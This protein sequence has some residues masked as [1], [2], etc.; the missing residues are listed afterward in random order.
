MAH[1]DNDKDRNEE[2][3][4]VS[5]NK[6][7]LIMLRKWPWVLLSLVIWISLAFFYLKVKQPTY[8]RTGKVLIKDEE[9]GGSIANPLEAFADLGMFSSNKVLLDEIIKMESPD[10]MEMVVRRLN[11]AQR[12]ETPGKWHRNV[13]YGDSLPVTVIAPSWEDD[14][15]ASITINIAKNGDVTLSDL[16][17]NG[18]DEDF[19]QKTPGKLGIP[20]KTP[21]GFVTVAPTPGYQPGE[22]YTLYMDRMPIPNAVKFYQSNTEIIREDEQANVV[23]LTVYDKSG[24]RARDIISGIIDVYNE[25]WET[26]KDA[27]S[28]A[29]NKFIDER[30]RNIEIELGAIDKDISQ[31]Q[32]ENQMPDIQTAAA[33]YLQDNQLAEQHLLELTNLVRVAQYLRDYI[34]NNADKNEILPTFAGIGMTQ[35]A[36][37]RQIMEYNEMLSERNRLASNSSTNHPMIES[38]D[39]QLK[40]MRAAIIKSADNEIGSLNAQIDNVMGKKGQVE[41]QIA[42]API[43]ASEL[44]ESGRQQK[45]LENLYLFL[46]QKREENVLSQAFGVFNTE[47][48]ARPNGDKAPAKPRKMLILGFA[49][50][51]G[52]LTPFSIF[53]IQEVFNT[54]VTSKKDLENISAPLIGE[55][56]EWKKSKKT[57]LDPTTDENIV[58]EPDN[59]NSIN[60]AFRV[61]RTNITFMTRKQKGDTSKGGCV[62]MVTSM[63]PGNGKSFVSVNLATALS[64]RDR[65]V[66][67]IDGDLRHGSTSKAVGSPSK[68]IS[69]YLVGG[70]DDWR[71]M[72]VQDR[73]MQGAAVLPVGHFPPNP[74]ELLETERFENMIEEMRNEYDFVFVDCPPINAMADARIIEKLVDRCIFVI[75]AGMLERSELPEVERLYTEKSLKNMSIILNGLKN[76]NSAYHSKYGYHNV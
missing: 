36:L 23:I 50:L 62:F 29:T 8:M 42:K 15:S 75:R 32:S 28:I 44:L 68:G 20:I 69:D 65:K 38:L 14:D 27:L 7:F 39:A 6:V 51:M 60:D 72:V 21:I 53:Y 37:E 25:N 9:S 16:S 45:V 52:L 67:L 19:E 64:L 59:R 4:K 74:T 54:K 40:Q 63:T 56:P 46:L 18:E 26:H 47:I 71:T 2:I 34:K 31:F 48:I 13:V 73:A 35:S 55:I 12:F 3:N 10:V 33:L 66:L 76:V 17:L 61:L 22:E 5:L 58:V 70:V 43:Q 57:K 41:S 1:K 11:L 30:L 24:D 49:F